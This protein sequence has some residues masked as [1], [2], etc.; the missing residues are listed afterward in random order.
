MIPQEK[1][2]LKKETK[3]ELIDRI[4]D[5]RKMVDQLCKANLKLV[6]EQQETQNNL[7][8]I[9]WLIAV[10]KVAKQYVEARKKSETIVIQNILYRKL[11]KLV[12]DQHS[13]FTF[14]KYEI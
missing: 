5:L 7:S 1:R 3:D 13:K 6:D 14:Y 12:R 4:D 11:E 8:I 2:T 10:R 9:R